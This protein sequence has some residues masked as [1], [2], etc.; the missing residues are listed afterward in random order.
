MF[1]ER[2]KHK[3]HFKDLLNIQD[4]AKMESLMNLVMQLRKV[5]NH[6][7]LFQIQHAKSPFILKH[8]LHSPNVF[9][10]TQNQLAGIIPQTPSIKSGCDNPITF[11]LPK[12]VYDEIIC[13]SDP[14]QKY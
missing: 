11:K 6:P 1:Y 8:T 14:T 4:A 2:L 7:E 9:Q 13:T 3:V 5:C 10:T 12:L